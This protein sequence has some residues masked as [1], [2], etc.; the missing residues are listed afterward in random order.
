[1]KRRWIFIIGMMIFWAYSCE[2]DNLEIENFLPEESDVTD[3]VPVVFSIALDVGVETGTELVPM[4]RATENE[5][6]TRLYPAYKAVL[7]KKIGARWIVD[8]VI[9]AKFWTGWDMDYTRG[10]E[11][12]NLTLTLRPGTY[13]LCMFANL[14]TDGWNNGLRSGKVVEDPN[15]KDIKLAYAWQ[16]VPS[17]DRDHYA[18]YGKEVLLDEAFAGYTEFT[19]EKNTDLHSSAPLRQETV[20]LKRKVGAFRFLLKVGEGKDPT[21][22][23]GT[24]HFLKAYLRPTDGQHFPDGLDV[25]GNPWYKEGQPRDSLYMYLST[26]NDSLKSENGTYASCLINKGSTYYSMFFLAGEQPIHYKLTDFR[27]ISSSPGPVYVLKDEEVVTGI[28]EMNKFS[29]VSLVNTG[30]LVNSEVYNQFYATQEKDT[31]GQLV[32][33]AQLFSPFIQWFR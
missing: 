27:I 17:T 2:K 5:V 8:T 9:D 31:K 18:T 32:D 13:R 19:V 20:N 22:N 12:K 33:A 16:Y 15:D 23:I 26:V 4:S 30:E 14:L 28:L 6:L 3:G 1:M 29:G 21:F 10:K 11:L 7:V 24:A 25:W